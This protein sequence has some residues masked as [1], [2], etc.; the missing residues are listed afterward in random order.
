[1]RFRK[2][3]FGQ[4]EM[5]MKE[6]RKLSGKILTVLLTVMLLGIGSG[7]AQDHDPRWKSLSE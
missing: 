4:G 2:Y 3:C 5:E 1:M 7:G 6:R